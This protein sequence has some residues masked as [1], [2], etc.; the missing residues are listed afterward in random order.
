MTAETQSKEWNDLEEVDLA[1][2]IL[3]A[4]EEGK[5]DGDGLAYFISDN[6]EYQNGSHYTSSTEVMRE[7]LEN[8]NEANGVWN[9]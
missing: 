3:K 7:F 2:F 9:D 6:V 5:I 8:Y 1:W 4:Y